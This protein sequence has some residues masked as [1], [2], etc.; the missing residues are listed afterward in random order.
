MTSIT[1]AEGLGAVTQ[2]ENAIPL[3]TAVYAPLAPPPAAKA[4]PTSPANIAMKAVFLK[5]QPLVLG[6]IQ[7]LVSLLCTGIILANI[8]RL[9]VVHV[10]LSPFLITSLP[11]GSLN[12][13][14]AKWTRL[15]LVWASLVFNVINVIL[16]SLGVCI[17]ILTWGTFKFYHVILGVF[18]LQISFSLT[19]SV[20]SC[21]AISVRRRYR[22][23]LV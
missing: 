23:I 19:V 1:A 11:S 14:V 20:F 15:G 18:A 16:I 6:I 21:K 22:P 17:L 12:A 2:N 9:T 8:N 13:V 5:P 3:Q 10:V 7:I 4:S